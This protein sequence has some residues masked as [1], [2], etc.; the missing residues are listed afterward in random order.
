MI[1]NNRIKW[2]SVLFT[3]HCSLF[4]SMMFTS[5]DNFLDITP[6]GKVI[7]STGEEYRAMLTYEYKY[8]PKD[9]HMTTVRTDELKFTGSTASSDLDA[10]LDLWLWKDENPSPTTSYFSWRSYYHAIYIANYI[11]EHQEEI[12]DASAKTINQLVGEAYMMRAYCH[13]LLVNLYAEPYTHCT[14]ATT[15]GVPMMLQADVNAIPGSSSVEA[16]YSQVLSDI[17]EAEQRLNVTQWEEGENYRF[18]VISAQALRARTYLYMGRWQEALSAAQ[19]VIAAHGD[20]VDMNVSS[21]VLPDSYQ[22]AEN[23]VALEQFSSNLSTVINQPS[24]DFIN[25][26]RTGDQRRT[27]YFKRAT[28][29]T[30]T[31]QKSDGYCSFRSSEAYLT[32]AEAATQLNNLT[33]AIDYL[34]PLLQKRLNATAYQDALDLMTPMDKAQLLQEIYD[35]R[36]RELAFE[37]HRWYD[38]RRTTQ[39]ALTR[40]YGGQTY[41]LTPEKYTMRFP[42]E[43]VESNPEIERW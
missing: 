39:P 9:R 7:A 5:C 41:T 31:L 36:A 4:V 15:R 21:A 2:L 17:S 18:N 23:I 28:S 20:L 26:Y 37:G 29:T 3:I 1:K 27:R 30:W 38:L 6:T 22:S 19:A 34:K 43:A 33:G 10:Y 35:E 16:V 24:V 11:I 25:M 8:F 14:P 42:T 12:A 40:T 13:F 32:A